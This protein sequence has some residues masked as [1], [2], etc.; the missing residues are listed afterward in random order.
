MKYINPAVSSALVLFVASVTASPVE[1]SRTEVIEPI[2]KNSFREIDG[3]GK[4]GQR[5]QGGNPRTENRI[6]IFDGSMDGNRQV[7]PQIAVGGGYVFH[8]TNN[9]FVIYDKEGNFVDGVG[10]KAFNDGIDPKL[11]YCVNNKVF[12]LDIWPYWNKPEKPVNISISE[13]RD[14]LGA[15]NIYPV[16]APDGGD[17][18]GIG[19]SRQWIGYTFPG[20]EDRTFVLKMADAKKGRPATVYHFKGFLGQA[21]LTQDDEKDLY[22][23]S[24]T[25]KE[26]IISRV[27]DRGNGT[28]IVEEVGREAHNLEYTG[29]PPKSPQKGTD[30]VTSS[31]DRN[32][33]NLVLQ[34]GYLWFSHTVKC[35]GRAAVQWH[36]VR[37]NG[38][39]KQTGLISDPDTNY[40]Q[41]TIAVNKR[42]DVLVGF[43]ET[44]EN[45]Y[46]SPR[47]AFR[48]ANDRRGELRPIVKLGEGK[49]A[50][51]GVAWG[52]YSGC[53]IDGD[54]RID[55]WT[56]QSITDEEGKGDTVIAKAPFSR[57]R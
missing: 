56:I 24:F 17:G 10:N 29:W 2:H 37:L 9:G 32:P 53:A 34:G 42:L 19:C 27:R 3:K 7:D 13:S 26:I 16:P 43:Q 41:T 51:D 54:N 28:P 48:R 39:I 25:G 22:F 55:L 23:L 40:I 4:L 47:M 33:K 57:L 5:K 30:Q 11:F 35:E 38:S 45:M 15:W 18:G 31:G 6:L 46:I 49:G 1:P 14:P 20:G 50:T 36:Q 21:A 8:A 12:G 44:N 52:D